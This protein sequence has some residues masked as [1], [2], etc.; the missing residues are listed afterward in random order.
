MVC[1]CLTVLSG[2]ISAETDP[3]HWEVEAR[4][5]GGGKSGSKKKEEPATSPCPTREMGPSPRTQTEV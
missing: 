4:K 1:G 2:A 5:S 3:V